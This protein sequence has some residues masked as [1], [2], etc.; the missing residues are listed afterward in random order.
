[1]KKTCKLEYY[2]RSI[3]GWDTKEIISLIDKDGYEDFSA[4]NLIVIEEF[5]KKKPVTGDGFLAFEYRNQEYMYASI[6]PR[7]E[8][9]FAR[10]NELFIKHNVQ[11]IFPDPTDIEACLAIRE[12]MLEE[13]S[14]ERANAFFGVEND[15]AFQPPVYQKKETN[16]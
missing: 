1:M 2:L 8:A 13:M 15:R 7:L 5:P 10:I 11:P 3:G 12:D 4:D 9:V 6:R 14:Y 16:D